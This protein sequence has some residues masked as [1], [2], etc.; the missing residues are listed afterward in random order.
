[1]SITPLLQLKD[2]SCYYKDK[3]QPIFSGVNLT[4]N[5][6]DVLVFQG[7]S[8]SGKSTLLKCIS[9]LNLYTGDILYRGQTPQSFGIPAFR[10]KV[11][12]VPQRASL[13][14]GTPR[15]FL[16][17]VHT[18]AVHSQSSTSS[19]AASAFS[20]IF[21]TKQD[22]PDVT[23]HDAI[24]LA[25]NWGVEHD[26]WDR[27]WSNLSGG[28]AQ[29]V[30]LALAVGLGTAEVL[31]LDEP[32]S[33]LDSESSSRV[34]NYLVEK[35]KARNSNLKALVWITHSPEQGERVG[36]RFV[37]VTPQGLREEYVHPDV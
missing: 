29:R 9:H 35:V 31:L 27:N 2:V 24:D 11:M 28:E 4:L 20:G 7:K 23:Y 30:A 18:F 36:T 1:M 8:G 16:K 37:R 5:E 26:L 12:Y 21:G 32:T 25:E 34:E 6:G 13:L 22:G 3:T 15:D 19:K 14:P 33:A 17:A 10:T